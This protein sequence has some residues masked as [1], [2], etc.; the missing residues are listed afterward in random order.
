[1][2]HTVVNGSLLDVG[3]G[4]GALTF[5][6]LKGGFDRA[7]IVEASAGYTAAATLKT[8]RRRLNAASESGGRLA[9]RIGGFV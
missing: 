3:A 8:A 9:N 5:E 6:L 1:M 2:P 7:V 4:V